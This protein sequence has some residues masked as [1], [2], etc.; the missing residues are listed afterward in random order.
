M[1]KKIFN[2]P[3]LG[4]EYRHDRLLTV[5]KGDKLGMLG[6][7]ENHMGRVA[8]ALYLLRAD[9]ARSVR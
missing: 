1:T 8:D 2:T 6:F 9:F 3:E 4:Q 7:L 5:P